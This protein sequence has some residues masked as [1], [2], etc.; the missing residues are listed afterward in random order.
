MDNNLDKA[1]YSLRMQVE[2][3]QHVC[4]RPS[5]ELDDIMALLKLSSSSQHPLVRSAHNRFVRLLSREQLSCFAALGL[6]L[7]AG[8]LSDAA[9]RGD[10]TA[11]YSDG[12]G[13]RS[14]G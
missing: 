11:N 12:N 2:I 4:F 9:L 5:Q 3:A 8:M 7:K 10:L 1:L 13:K 6:N 14:K